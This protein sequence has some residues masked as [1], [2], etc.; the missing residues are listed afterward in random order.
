MANKLQSKVMFN[1]SIR[2]LLTTLIIALFVLSSCTQGGPLGMQPSEDE[3]VGPQNED[4]AKKLKETKKYTFTSAEGHQVAFIQTHEGAWQAHV[5]GEVLQI[6]CE[7]AEE[8]GDALARLED[9][10]PSAQKRHIHIIAHH[11]PF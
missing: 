9:K 1:K 6:V 10:A 8:V 2:Y 11:T 3:T 4:A 5:Q 7:D